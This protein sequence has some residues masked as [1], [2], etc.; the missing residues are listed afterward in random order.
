MSKKKSS[1]NTAALGLHNAISKQNRDLSQKK[2]NSLWWSLGL[3]LF[4][5]VIISIWFS[6][7]F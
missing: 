2:D 7:T 4:S 6:S 1:H 5:A 3:V